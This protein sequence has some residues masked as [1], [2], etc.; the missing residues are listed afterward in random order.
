MR[1][2][3]IY[4]INDKTV[5]IVP[6]VAENGSVYT[7]VIEEEHMTIVGECPSALI[8]ESKCFY[9]SPPFGCSIKRRWG[10]IVKVNEKQIQAQF[11]F[12]KKYMK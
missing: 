7:V 2:L 5:C 4:L 6:Y 12:T 9:S 3:N 8:E 10:S 11:E 1:I